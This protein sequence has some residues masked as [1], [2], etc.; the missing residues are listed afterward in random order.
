MK[1]KINKKLSS[2][3]E[4]TATAIVT[5]TVAVEEAQPR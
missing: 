4:L 1:N 5:V 2:I 3:H